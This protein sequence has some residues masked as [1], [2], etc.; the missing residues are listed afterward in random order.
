LTKW[1]LRVQAAAQRW[2][3]LLLL[4]LAPFFLFMGPAT[5]PVLLVV[6]ALLAVL[7]IK[8]PATLNRTPLDWALLLMAVMVLVS[9]WATFSIAFSLPKIAGLVFGLGLF[10]AAVAAGR[11]ARGG[12]LALAAVYLALGA[13]VAAIGLLGTSWSSKFP[14]LAAV[15]AR[16]PSALVSLPGAENGLQPN[17]VAGVLVWVTPVALALALAL[18]LH[19]DALVQAYGGPTT[20]AAVVSVTLMALGSGGVLALTQSRSALFGL[21]LA[22]LAMGLLASRRVRWIT[23]TLLVVGLLGG[24]AFFGQRIKV[25]Y[26]ESGNGGMASEPAQDLLSLDQRVDIW[27]KAVYG[28]EDFAL[29]G[30]GMNTFRKLA[31]VLYPSAMFRPDEDLGH[32]HNTWLQVALDLGLP[33][34]VGYVAV[35]MVTIGMLLQVVQVTHPK[36]QRG[37]SD[38]ERRTDVDHWS[39]VLRPPSPF[40][41][42]LAL[43][44]LGA[45]AGSFGY[46]FTDTVA[47][48][49]R[50]GFLWWLLLALA[51]LVWMQSRPEG[52]YSVSQ[53]VVPMIISGEKGQAVG[54]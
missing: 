4:A 38:E 23:L 30:M 44:I 42:P 46:G 29:T 50:P 32:A 19:F 43:G 18:W 53:S 11:A 31:G 51:V 34:L 17:E 15:T 45:F 12:W 39:F 49:A 28:I 40:L 22:L 27:S 9:L 37:T 25:L 5:S 7:W 6:P 1:S 21:A 16:L 8:R 2:G 33:G 41:R 24:V 14:L 35:W 36:P 13:G 47:L 48:G 26:D 54:T 3:W 52:V 20:T 10:Y